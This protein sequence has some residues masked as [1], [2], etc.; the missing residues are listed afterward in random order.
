MDKLAL[1]L[2]IDGLTIKAAL[3]S[4][5]KGFMRVE[6]LD[7]F[8]LFDSLEQ[9]EEDKS[10]KKKYDSIDQSISEN[11]EEP[12][13]FDHEESFQQAVDVAQ[14][15]GNVDVV[16]EMFATML[17]Q[18]CPIAF[19]LSNANVFYKTL[20]TSTQVSTS[21][22]KKLVWK[23]LNDD[24]KVEI[25]YQNIGVIKHDDKSCLGM[26][27]ND[28]L[29]F[30]NLVIEAFRLSARQA[31]PIS[32]IDSLEFS[33]AEY[34]SR[35]VEFE[36]DER[37]AVIYFS[38]NYSKVFFTKGSQ[39]TY[40]LPTIHTGVKS[41]KVCEIVFSKMLYELDFKGLQ[42]P[43][44]IILAG[45]LEQA[46]ADEYFKEK[47]P[48]LHT[49]R[50][51]ANESTLA[52]EVRNLADRTSSYAVAIGLAMKSL[53]PNKF[54]KYSQ[55]FLP[56][57]VRDKQ[58]QFV[59]AWHGFAMMG[60]LFVT[61]LF[62][63]LQN[64]KLNQSVQETRVSL[65]AINDELF[66]LADVERHVDSLRMKINNIETG[67]SLIDSLSGETTRWTPLI[68]AFSDAFEKLG[69]FSVNKFVSVSNKKMVV[70]INLSNLKQVALLERF[71]K[72]SKVLSF[73]NKETEN[74]NN[75][76]LQL[77]IECDLSNQEIK[78]DSSLTLAKNDTRNPDNPKVK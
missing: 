37:L 43:Q 26:M 5:E 57:R 54:K 21:K 2:Y 49:I 14:A 4:Q 70:E 27:H 42:A 64:V 29:I 71:I 69:F 6:R 53:T 11:D 47:F 28:P 18:G 76:L 61:I 39:I 52:P 38:Q 20:Y 48:N 58:S 31:S 63:F 72:D 12:F 78:A 73:V 68:E 19:N 36:S 33:L 55:N 56:K 15:R 34:L 10:K 22:L 17:P 45:E 74:S 51:D 32:L 30:I 50:L 25:N 16:I 60:V 1:G 13:G 44:K 7:T 66:A 65:N 35:T 23:E 40:V 24:S 46:K 41:S 8:K 3:V 9:Q 59:V 62:L 77:T 67:T 75:D